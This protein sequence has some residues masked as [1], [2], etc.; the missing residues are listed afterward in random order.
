MPVT[1]LLRRLEVLEVPDCDCPR[2]VMTACQKA[3]QPCRDEEGNLIACDCPHV[4]GPPCQ[5]IL[6]SD[7]GFLET[8]WAAKYVDADPRERF[9]IRWNGKVSEVPPE[10]ALLVEWAARL[11]AGNLE[12]YDDPLHEPEPAVVKTRA[13]RVELYAWRE[14]HGMHLYAKGDLTEE[15]SDDVGIVAGRLRNGAAVEYGLR[16][17]KADQ[18]ERERINTPDEFRRAA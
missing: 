3:G 9:P 17:G 4:P 1:L 15:D 12:E 16:T 2:V 7:E 13:A 11:L 14:E 6:D 10:Q 8:P 5:H 18:V